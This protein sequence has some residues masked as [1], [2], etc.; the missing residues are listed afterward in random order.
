LTGA[1]GST[2]P[3]GLTGAT[4]VQGASGSTGFTGAT[5]PG[6]ITGGA[7]NKVTYFSGPTTLTSDTDLHWDSTNN[8]LGVNLGATGPA[9]NIHLNGNFLLEEALFDYGKNTSLAPSSLTSIL[10]MTLGTYT[11]A[12]YE[13]V[14]TSSTNA[15]A[16]K[17]FAVVNGSTVQYAEFSTPDIGTTADLVLSVGLSGGS[18]ILYGQ[19]TSL[20]WSIKTTVRLL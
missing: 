14:A 19:C 1:T 18:I 15:R 12:F 9:A 17:I 20:T 7:A 8:R 2:G 3:I 5:G 13:Y 4:G 10:S 6:T 11:A 16:G